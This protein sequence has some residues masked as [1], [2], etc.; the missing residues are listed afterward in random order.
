MLNNLLILISSLFFVVKGAVWATKYAILLAQNFQLSK[1]V[2]GFI[3]VAV[4]SI[5]P[6]TFIAI[7]SSL[8]GV[9]AFGLGTLFGGNVADMTIVIAIIIG[10][11]GREIKI[12][13][14]ILKNNLSYPFL[15]LIPITL[16]LD[17]YYSRWE[18]LALIITGLIFYYLAF[19]N[20]P[21]EAPKIKN[22]HQ[23]RKNFTLLLLSM[24]VLL[25]GS[26]FTVT[27]ATALAADWGV[28]RILI[29]MLIVGLGTTIPEMLFSL[30]ALKKHNDSLAIGDILG[31]VLAD[32]TVVVGILAIMSPFAF[33]T[34]I[35]YVTGGFMFLAA[36]IL[37]FFMYS[38][39]T[40]S[41]KESLFLL[42]FWIVFV[43][44]E[45]L[46]SH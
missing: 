4:I 20:N 8:E 11:S 29:G 42:F 14:K 28:S 46:I 24:A 45:Y 9:P 41:K 32:G 6:E 1:Y 34:K 7:N 39:K 15:F 33:P 26:H 13:S 30:Q 36:I 23:S 44:T 35:V 17:G 40:I 38:H 21:S 19:K 12:E 16:G 31:T 3:V 22:D 10:L 37:S 2:I 27:S 5:L 18:G 43:V 25:L